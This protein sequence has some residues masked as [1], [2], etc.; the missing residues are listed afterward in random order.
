MRSHY[1]IKDLLKNLPFYSSEFKKFKKRKKNF[2]NARFLSKLPFF[3]KKPKELT[4]YQLSR[5]LPFFPKRSKR[6][7]RLTNIKC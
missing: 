4:N 2:T 7:K 6:P 5:E 1:K 3:L